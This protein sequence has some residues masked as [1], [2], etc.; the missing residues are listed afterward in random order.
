MLQTAEWESGATPQHAGSL[1]LASF[2]AQGWTSQQVPTVQQ[3]FKPAN[4]QC[5]V[6]GSHKAANHNANNRKESVTGR[7]LEWI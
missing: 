2:S 3:I 6:S 5:I 1:H 7:R 4:W